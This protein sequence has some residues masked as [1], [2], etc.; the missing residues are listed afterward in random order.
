MK[1]HFF[2]MIVA[3]T[4]F[5]VSTVCNVASGQV[6]GG[7]LG[8]SL[9]GT[10][11]GVT[12][13]LNGAGAVGS[14]FD[15]APVV[16]RSRGMVDRTQGLTRDTRERVRSRTRS[17]V[18]AVKT[19]GTGAIADA[20]S[21]AQGVAMLGQEEAPAL[22]DAAASSATAAADATGNFDVGAT[23]EELTKSGTGGAPA[24]DA[25]ADKASAKDAALV[26]PV[27]QPEAQT[28]DSGS[29]TPQRSPSASARGSAGGE[30][31]AAIQ[32]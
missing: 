31:E 15:T 20:T 22:V 32:M 3:S 24:Q 1:Q 7:G 4:A 9:G 5:A 18:S 2:R 8:G 29:E 23:T 6:L 11:N 13:T 17:A 21:S 10:L 30:G 25:P 26:S 14:T 27:L 12:G 19:E 16:G 28:L